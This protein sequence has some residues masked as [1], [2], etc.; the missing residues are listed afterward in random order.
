[1]AEAEA[2]L[3]KLEFTLE[4]FNRY[5][6]LRGNLRCKPQ[7]EARELLETLDSRDEILKIADQC[8]SLEEELSELALR[9]TG[10]TV[11]LAKWSPGCLWTSPWTG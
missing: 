11:P 6:A 7:V 4:L 5:K 2:Q 9:K 1:M 8:R 10:Y 3:S